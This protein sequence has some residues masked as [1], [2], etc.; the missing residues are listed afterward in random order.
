M[1]LTP[2][3]KLGPYE[4]LAP[5][6][7]NVVFDVAADGKTALRENSEKCPIGGHF[8]VLPSWELRT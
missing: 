1:P 6:G 3:D 2:G 5:I 4:I 8:S 7:A